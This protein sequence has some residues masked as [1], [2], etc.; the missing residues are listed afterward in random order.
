M[1]RDVGGLSHGQVMEQL[2]I[3][4]L[5][6]PCPLVNIETWATERCIEEIYKIPPEKLNDDRIDRT[7][8]A[9]A[10]YI[11]DKVYQAVNN[12][13]K[14]RSAL[15]NKDIVVIGDR[16]MLTKPDIIAMQNK[17]IKFLGP[18]SSKE[19]ELILKDIDT[20]MAGWVSVPLIGD[21]VF[22]DEK[23]TYTTENI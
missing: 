19:R 4:R 5:E 13:E 18:L 2:I 16:A 6:A 22:N 20:C 8:D 14:M 1:Q 23:K 12:L 11:S 21:Y 3:N 9:V 10:D 17:G 15:N 7:L